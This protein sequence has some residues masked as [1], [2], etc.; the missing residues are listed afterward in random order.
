MNNFLVAS[1]V[2]T[3]VLPTCGIFLSIVVVAVVAAVVVVV[4]AVVAVVTVVNA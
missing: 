1:F 4:V 3:F 2:R